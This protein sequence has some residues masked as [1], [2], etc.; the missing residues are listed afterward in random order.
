MAVEG[1]RDT[2]S[3]RCEQVDAVNLWWQSSRR[4]W[5][6]TSIRECKREIDRWSNSLSYLQKRHWGDTSQ[7]VVGPQPYHCQAEG[8]DIWAGKEWN[9]IWAQ[10][11]RWIPFLST[12]IPWVPLNNRFEALNLRE[13]QVGMQWK[14]HSG[15]CLG[16]VSQLYASRL[17]LPSRK[18]G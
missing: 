9:L 18:N 14:V 11:C 13:R 15:G 1:I 6:V 3:M 7:T 10:H 2:A 8:R 17:P 16:W 12:P 5:R 4:R